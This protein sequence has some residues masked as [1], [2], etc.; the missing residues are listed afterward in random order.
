MVLGMVEEGKGTKDEKEGEEE[1]E[2]EDE[3]KTFSL[4]TCCSG[5][6]NNRDNLSRPALRHESLDCLLPGSLISIFLRSKRMRRWG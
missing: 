2:E 3:R 5:S 1:E 4:T 6:T